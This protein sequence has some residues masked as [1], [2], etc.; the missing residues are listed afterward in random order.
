M[1][2][3]SLDRIHPG[4]FL[5]LFYVFVLECVYVHHMHV[6]PEKA[7]RGRQSPLELEL[8]LGS[9]V[10]AVL[11]TDKPSLQPPILETPAWLPLA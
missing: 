10:R 4:I 11:L 1:P 7:R 8:Q 9:S 6:V 3:L 2:L 5:I